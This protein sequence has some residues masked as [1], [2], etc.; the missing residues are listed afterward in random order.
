MVVTDLGGEMRFASSVARRLMQLG[1][2]TRGDRRAAI[3]GDWDDVNHVSACLIFSF[4]SQEK[5]VSY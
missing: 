3:G 2:L 1:A 4:V 5:M